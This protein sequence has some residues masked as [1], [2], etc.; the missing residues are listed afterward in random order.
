MLL[1][2]NVVEGPYLQDIL[3][4]PEA[5]RRSLSG[6]HESVG[7]R[8]FA[9]AVAE[10]K[11]RR[12]VLTG[13]GSSLFA[14]YPLHLTLTGQGYPSLL[15]ETSELIHYLE[16]VLDSRTLVIAVSQSGQSAEVVRLLDVVGGRAPLIGVTNNPDSPLAALADAYVLMQAGVESSVSCKTYVSSLLALEWLGAILTGQ[17]LL[18]V[19]SVLTLAVPAVEAYLSGWRMHVAELCSVIANVKQVFVTGRGPSLSTALT[20]G[21]ILKESARF[22]AEGLSSA[23]FRHGP[24][25]M[26]APH[27]FVLV[28]AGDS[29]SD[30]LN[31]RLAA[32]V[33]QA[34]GR[35]AI[36]DCSAG[37][38]AFRIPQVPDLIRPVVEILP[39]QMMSLALAARSG[40]EAGR[41][42]LA[43]KVTAVE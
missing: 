37:L 30:A 17:N 19:G 7:L 41:F 12:I 3:N 33:D 13:M 15:I 4:Q 21:L 6:F 26:I 34:G 5:L 14:L 22:P 10:G 24:F 32:D 35:S 43:T 16:T 40:R 27:V 18:E 9:Q 39:V 38:R 23:A 29:R 8:G 1:E 2:M 31:R 36:V 42:E 25:E 28:L 11:Y 20:G